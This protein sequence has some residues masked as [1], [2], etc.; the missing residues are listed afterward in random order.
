MIRQGERGAQRRRRVSPAYFDLSV[1][2]EIA[3]SCAGGF[4]VGYEDAAGDRGADRPG[5]DPDGRVE[6]RRGSGG[7][8]GGVGARLGIPS[9][10]ASSRSRSTGNSDAPLTS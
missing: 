4:G 5:R 2:E 6:R 7:S 3:A 9:A 8:A 10:A 1:A